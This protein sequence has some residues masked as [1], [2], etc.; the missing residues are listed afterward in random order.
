M[1]QQKT[2]LVTRLIV[3]AEGNVLLLRRSKE[4]VYRPDRWEVPGGRVD[5][6]ERLV[7]AAA[8]EMSEETGI[9]L[10]DLEYINTAIESDV[11]KDSIILFYGAKLQ[12]KPNITLSNEHQEWAWANSHE[13]RKYNAHPIV[14]R[15]LESWF[16]SNDKIQLSTRAGGEEDV[17]IYSD[18]GSRG[19]PGPSATGYV[20]Y[21]SDE[22]ELARGGTYLGVATNNQAEYL[23]VK[24]GLVRAKELGVKKVQY[25]LDS[26]LVVK[27]M[28]G[29][30]QIK[31]KD[32]WPI[33]QSIKDLVQEFEAVHFQ[34]VK[35]NK[36]KVAD[37]IVNEVLDKHEN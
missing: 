36:N 10:A 1:S 17:V 20:I 4:A 5:E 12:K 28:S 11:N 7:E 24:E 3:E 22:A 9:D 8:R 13:W 27:Q 35:R 18:G 2:Q 29:E 33:H 31:N 25:Y 21:D 26:M 15:E 34:H 32:L 37:S 19:N 16:S 23:A 30:Y 6:G 14:E